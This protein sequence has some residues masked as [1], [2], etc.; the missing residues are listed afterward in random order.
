MLWFLMI[1][2]TSFFMFII[3]VGAWMYESI[4]YIEGPKETDLE[5]KVKDLKERYK[6]LRSNM[7]GS[8]LEDPNYSSY[9][10]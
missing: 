4:E 10:R 7:E 9:Y 5:K 3:F 6:W 1:I 2:F 8:K